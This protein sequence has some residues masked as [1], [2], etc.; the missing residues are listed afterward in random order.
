MFSQVTGYVLISNVHTDY[1]NMSRLRMI[2]G[3][4]LLHVTA[5]EEHYSLYVDYNYKHRSHSVGLKQLHFTSLFG[6][7]G[8]DDQT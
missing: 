2:R 3:Q 1:L 8:N 7:L 4:E 6:N 5:D